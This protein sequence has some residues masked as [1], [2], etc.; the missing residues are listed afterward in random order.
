MCSDRATNDRP[1]LLLVVGA[2]GAIGSTIAAATIVMAHDPDQV[3]PGMLSAFLFPELGSARDIKMVG[4]DPAP[5]PLS[6]V[7]S[8]QGILPEHL[9][10]PHMSELDRLTIL[11]APD[12]SGSPAHQVDRLVDQ[13]RRLCSQDPEARAVMVNLLPAAK[14]IEC[15]AAATLD[16]LQDSVGLGDFPDLIYTIAAI[17][18]GVPVVNFTP[19]GI[20]LPAVVAAAREQ[21]IPLIGRDG[22]TGQTYFKVVLASAL[23]ARHLEVDGW[24]SLNILGNADGA[25]LMDP[26]RAAGKLANKTDLLTDILGYSPGERYGS[27][28][29]KVRIDYYPPRGDAKEAWDVIDFKGIFGMP[30]S[31]RVNLVGRDSI[32]AAPMVLDL[33][34][35]ATAL[36]SSGRGG[37]VPELAFFFKK[38]LGDNP[39]LTF[40]DQLVALDLLAEDCRSAAAANR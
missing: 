9:W 40:Q 17:R 11:A 28:T 29:H 7:L 15:P 22:K 34:R 3:L 20:E 30:M 39:P 6:E 36:K 25:N 13:I 8:R 2:K 27:P 4:W 10:R 31:L 21:S 1:L 32:L 14:S 38:P 23:K 24:Y 35:W 37:L 26:E 33:A 16:E 18:C 5:G 12:A 19:N